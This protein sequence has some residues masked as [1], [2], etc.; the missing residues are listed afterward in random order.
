MKKGEVKQF[1]QVIHLSHCVGFLKIVTL[2]YNWDYLYAM[3]TRAFIGKRRMSLL[4]F[5][6]LLSDKAI[7]YPPVQTVTLC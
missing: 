3:W 1:T 4:T 6:F 5:Y 2:V 7:K